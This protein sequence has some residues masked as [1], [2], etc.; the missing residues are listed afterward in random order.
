M[1]NENDKTKAYGA[2]IASCAADLK[3]I[4]ENDYKWKVF[5]PEVDC[6]MTG[7]AY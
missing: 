6:K 1:C 4:E 7:F 3:K 2:A 5:E